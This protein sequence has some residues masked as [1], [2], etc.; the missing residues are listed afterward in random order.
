MAEKM[1]KKPV[2]I[3]L[4]YE[5]KDKLQQVLEKYKREDDEKQDQ[6]EL[7]LMRILEIADN[8]VVRGTHPELE[9]S[10]KDVDKTIATL[11]KQINGIV[12]GQDNIIFGLR[13]DNQDIAEKLE[14]IEASAK[15]R[16]ESANIRT[17]RADELIAVAEEKAKQTKEQAEKEIDSAMKE[18]DSAMKERDAAIKGRLDAEE[19]A[20]EKT[21]NNE[22]L[23][24]QV[25][26][27]KKEAEEY[28]KMQ[29]QFLELKEELKEKE[30]EIKEIEKEAIQKA[31]TEKAVAELKKEQAVIEI[32]RKLRKEYQ[33]QLRTADREIAVLKA[34]L[35][36]K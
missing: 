33:E 27:L 9:S 25:A 30:R 16:V 4:T 18:I 31:E 17:A 15:E 14:K 11:I 7:A 3:R 1:E 22:F 26:E 5:T 20:K 13:K 8:D 12:S 6:Q 10:L 23:L 29:N 28:K 34:K 35:G 24:K 36:E 2:S 19:L 32:E 21:A